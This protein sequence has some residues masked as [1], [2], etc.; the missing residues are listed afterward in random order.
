MPREEP[1]TMQTGDSTAGSRSL[2]AELRD[3]SRSQSKVVWKLRRAIDDV[4]LEWCTQACMSSAA[5]FACVLGSSVA[6]AADAAETLT[7]S[8]LD[9][10]TWLTASF[11][12]KFV[13]FWPLRSTTCGA[14]LAHSVMSITG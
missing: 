9:G 11:V 6:T 10:L 7:Q 5:P 12:L 14:L 3:M 8:P 4:S 1:V 13:I 2:S